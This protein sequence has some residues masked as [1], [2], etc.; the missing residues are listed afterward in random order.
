MNE[1]EKDREYEYKIGVHYPDFADQNY[2]R[3]RDEWI[4]AKTPRDAIAQWLTNHK[5]W[6]RRE[7]REMIK[8]FESKRVEA[9]EADDDHDEEDW[10]E[11]AKAAEYELQVLNDHVNETAR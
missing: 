11:M 6:I 2:L 8:V 9:A 1:L 4:A 3:D 5:G 7:E 10:D